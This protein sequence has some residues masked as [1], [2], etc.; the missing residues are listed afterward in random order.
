MQIKCLTLPLY[1]LICR[2]YCFL[3]GDQIVPSL[4]SGSLYN[5]LLSPFSGTP[6]VLASFLTFWYDKVFLAYLVY[7]LSQICNQLLLCRTLVPLNSKLNI[8]AFNPFQ[9]A[10][11]CLVSQRR[12]LLCVGYLRCVSWC[13][14]FS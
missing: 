4:A 7:F 9:I 12:I 14:A 10:V 11:L 8:P 2:M 13:G 3:T 5:W 1:L 6:G